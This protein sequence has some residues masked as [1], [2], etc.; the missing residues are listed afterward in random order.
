[1]SGKAAAHLKDFLV[2]FPQAFGEVH[3]AERCQYG[4]LHEHY[5]KIGGAKPDDR[6]YGPSNG[7]KGI[8]EG[9]DPFMYDDAGQR[10]S[11]WD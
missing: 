1:M 11:C 10:K 2:K 6:Q 3:K 8:E 7:W 9:F 5:G 4:N